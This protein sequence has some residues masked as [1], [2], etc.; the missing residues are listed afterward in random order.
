MLAATMALLPQYLDYHRQ[1]LNEWVQICSNKILFTKTDHEKLLYSTRG[2]K[3]VESVWKTYIKL[4]LK[5]AFQYALGTHTYYLISLLW[6][7]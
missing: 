6:G 1:D 4:I 7:T 5:N 2:K 3:K